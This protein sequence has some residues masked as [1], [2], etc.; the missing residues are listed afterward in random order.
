MAEHAAN[1]REFDQAIRLYKEALQYDPEHA[2]TLLALAKLY[3]Q[4]SIIIVLLNK[5]EKVLCITVVKVDILINFVAF[6]LLCGLTS[7]WF[8]MLV[9]SGRCQRL[10]V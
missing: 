5:N 4:V 8:K 2:P 7:T 3:M 10:S 6:S 1:Q 9:N